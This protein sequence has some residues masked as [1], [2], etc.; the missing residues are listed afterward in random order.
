MRSARA[1]LEAGTS[2]ASRTWHREQQILQIVRPS[3]LDN[4]TVDP[5]RCDIDVAQCLEWWP[6]CRQQEFITEELLEGLGGRVVWVILEVDVSMLYANQYLSCRGIIVT[7]RLYRILQLAVFSSAHLP[8][9]P[10]ARS[11]LEFKTLFHLF[12]HCFFVR[13]GTSAAIAAQSLPLCVFTESF[14]FLS[15]SSDH[16]PAR[17][18]VGSMFSAKPSCHLCRHSLFVRPGTN[19]AIAAQSLPP[20]VCTASFSLPTLLELGLH[21]VHRLGLDSW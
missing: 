13:P 5:N 11:M 14:N 7:V 1:K 12:Q 2:N 4:H 21:W 17:A 10:P 18:V 3:I 15:S 8:A 6:I 16:L 20:C 9:C 19:A